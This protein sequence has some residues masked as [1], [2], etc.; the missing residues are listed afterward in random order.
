MRER[1][2]GLLKLA[3][4]VLAALL[5]VQVVGVLRRLQPARRTAVPEPATWSP[6]APETNAPPSAGPM[7]GPPGMPP[8]MPPGRPMP[9]PRRG[10]R[11][12]GGPGPTLPP[13]LQARVD[14]VVQSE[15]LGPIMRPPPM[16]LL[17]IAGQDVLLRA[18]NGQS[19][20]VREGGELGGVRLVRIGTNRVLVNENGEDKELMIFQGIGGE[21]LLPQ[22][23]EGTP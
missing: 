5:L 11:G 13:D 19:G 2:G 14:R 4:A 10:G 9:G 18:P 8:G 16:A 21:S 20:L 7:A 23:K 3:S 1:A 6:P 15:V 12:P 22:K 17:G